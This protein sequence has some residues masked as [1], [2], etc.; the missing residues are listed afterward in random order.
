VWAD[1][2][3]DLRR[4]KSVA[5]AK[6]K[7]LPLELAARAIAVGDEPDR[8]SE[9]I[10]LS[11]LAQILRRDAAAQVGDCLSRLGYGDPVPAGQDFGRKIRPAMESKTGTPSPACVARDRDVTGPSTHFKSPHNSAAL[12]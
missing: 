6:P 9:H 2:N 12:L 3:V 7:E 4:G 1:A 11:G 10:G 5:V 8:Q